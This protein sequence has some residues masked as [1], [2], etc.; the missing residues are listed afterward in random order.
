MCVCVSV[1]PIGIV[2]SPGGENSS[3]GI[4]QILKSGWWSETFFICPYTGNNDPNWRTHIFRNH[5]PVKWYWDVFPKWGSFCWNRQLTSWVSTTSSFDHPRQGR[6]LAQATRAE[7][8]AE[9]APGGDEGEESTSSRIM[10]N[11]WELS[12]NS[13]RITW[14]LVRNLQV[15]LGQ[16]DSVHFIPITDV[17]GGRAAAENSGGHGI[18]TGANEVWGPGPWGLALN[19]AVDS[20]DDWEW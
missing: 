20:V 9:D 17:P 3:K 8:A 7:T 13:G 14:E 2:T 1:F 6:G 12:Q 4:L 5:Q 16:V 19:S 18:R 15:K 11:T 10:K